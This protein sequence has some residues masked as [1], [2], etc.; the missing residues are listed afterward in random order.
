MATRFNLPPSATPIGDTT[1]VIDIASRDS[2]DGYFFPIGTTNTP[3]SALDK[4]FNTTSITIQD[5]V[6][7]GAAD[8][9][10]YVSFTPDTKQSG[11][12]IQGITMEFQVGHWYTDE[13][14]ANL[15]SGKWIV[16]PTSESWGYI[17][18]LGS[19]IIEKVEITAGDQTL[20]QITGDYAQVSLAS[21]SNTNTAIGYAATGIG[22]IAGGSNGTGTPGT[23]PI[24]ENKPFITA[25]GIYQVLLPII[26]GGTGTDSST[27]EALPLMSCGEGSIRIN[28]KLRE[29]TDA[30]RKFNGTKTSPM[31]SPLGQFTTFRDTTTGALITQQNATQPPPFRDFRL[32][33]FGQ[34]T[35][36]PQREL[37]LRKP[38]EQLMQFSQSFRFSEPL[39]YAVT[40]TQYGEDTIDISL[41]LE[42]NYPT[43]EIFFVFKR[44]SIIMNNEWT[45]YTPA[46]GW[47]GLSPAPWLRYGS[48]YINGILLDQ[49]DGD[50]WLT[51]Y[52][53]H[54]NGGLTAYN[55]FV[56]GYTFARTPDQ[57][58]PSG[59]VNMSKATS[60]RLKLTVN[61][62]PSILPYSPNVPNFPEGT[63]QGWEVNVYTVYYNWVRFENGLVQKLYAD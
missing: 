3:F 6:H 21:S 24:S 62:P 12:L 25:D 32:V 49:G 4:L 37:Y 22:L 60:V 26:G 20:S 29:F 7:Q 50:W 38:V 52:A 19:A 15:Q 39:K 23:N 44:T 56:Y 14:V 51:N 63:N 30:V 8:W 45:N 46:P 58:Q 1:T 27:K 34:L 61:V 2:Q 54:H 16:D 18:G 48:L 47:S 28:I 42:L 35:S 55:N 33:T 31:D 53:Q 13:A 57:H 40:K 41:P 9:G 11:D 10:G 43:K 5:Y 59:Y 36:G 17:N